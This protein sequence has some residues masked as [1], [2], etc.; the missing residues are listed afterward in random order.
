MANEHLEKADIIAKIKEAATEKIS[1]KVEEEK[2]K[3]EERISNELTS[4]E[5]CLQYIKNKMV[6]KI[7]ESRY[8]VKEYIIADEETFFKDYNKEVDYSW[9][10]GITFC[11][12]NSKPYEP[13]FKVNGEAYYDMR[14]IVRHYEETFNRYSEDLKRLRENFSQ[15]EAKAESLKKQEPHIKK[16]IEQYKQIDIDEADED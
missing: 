3:L 12:P 14:Y 2:K 4:V 11:D 7:I 15:I 8:A 9:V 6:F 16:L 1:K 13:V 10:K 5:R